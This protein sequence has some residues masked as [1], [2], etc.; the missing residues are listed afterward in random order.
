V[1]GSNVVEEHWLRG[2]FIANKLCGAGEVVVCGVFPFPY[3]NLFKRGV[4]STAVRMFDESR[5]EELNEAGLV[6]RG[7]NTKGSMSAGWMTW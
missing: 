3:L 7:L 6:S 5:F 4:S 2:V 1:R